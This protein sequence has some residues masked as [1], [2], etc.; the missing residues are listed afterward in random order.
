MKLNPRIT[1][2]FIASVCAL[3]VLASYLTFHLAPPEGR[4]NYGEL[5]PPAPL[6]VLPMQTAEGKAWSVSSLKG[7][8]VLLQAGGGP[9]CDPDC[10]D[11]LHLS[12]QVRTAVGKEVERVE[13]LWLI[14][15][16]ARLDPAL[17]AEHP[18]LHVARVAGEATAGFPLAREGRAQLYLVD[19]LG[20]LVLRYPAEPE[21]RRVLKD[22]ERLLKYSRVG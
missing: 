10:R 6:S 15:P 12:R 2:L 22:L 7:R 13:R 4:M 9:E 17:L 14:P 5:L 1:L 3:P 20:N 21:G 8:W 11:A 18:G 19:P 16:G